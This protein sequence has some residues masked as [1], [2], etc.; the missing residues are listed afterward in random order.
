MDVVPTEVVVQSCDDSATYAFNH[1]RV[2][3]FVAQS[4]EHLQPNGV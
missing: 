1:S 4:N 3:R 2:Y